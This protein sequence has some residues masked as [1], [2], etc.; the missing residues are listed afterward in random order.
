MVCVFKFRIRMDAT[1]RL[2]VPYLTDLVEV[3]NWV[4]AAEDNSI[5]FGSERLSRKSTLLVTI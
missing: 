3:T 4:L 2:V 1:P 5:G